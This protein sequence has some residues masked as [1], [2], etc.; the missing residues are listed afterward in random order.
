ME[1]LITIL[2]LLI[3]FTIMV[4]GFIKYLFILFMIWLIW[5]GFLRILIN[6]RR[7]LGQNAIHELL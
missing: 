3:G 7:K 1:W 2:V 5:D 4:T 6:N